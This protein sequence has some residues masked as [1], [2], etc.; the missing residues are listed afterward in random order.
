MTDSIDVLLIEPS[1]KDA[2]KTL[3]AIRRAKS[4]LTV[5]RIVDA[6]QATRLMFEQGLFTEQ[7]QIPGFI[8]VDLPIA[9]DDVKHALLRLKSV[10]LD[11][12]VPI[13]TFSARR[14][15]KDI[16]DAHL[17]GVHMNIQKSENP[18]EYADAV[19][20]MIRMWVNGSFFLLDA[21][22]G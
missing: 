22:A 14:S 20:R 18:T 21:E 8:I 3:E 4:D 16:L 5:V 1:D 15:A 9:G 10:C 13:V 7:P 17:L 6:S 19:D 2:R 11:S 12:P